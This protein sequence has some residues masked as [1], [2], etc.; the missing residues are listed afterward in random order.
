MDEWNNV[1]EIG[2]SSTN[3]RECRRKR[4]GQEEY[5]TTGWGL[6]GTG[7]GDTGKT[8]QR[9]QPLPVRMSKKRQREGQASCGC[10]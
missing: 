4:K 3:R 9:F 1:L 6:G 7:G 8:L 2:K 10:Q 5:Q